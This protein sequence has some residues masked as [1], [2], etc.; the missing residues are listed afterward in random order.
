MSRSWDERPVWAGVAVRWPDGRITAVE[1][2]Y[3]IGE[4]TINTE[5]VDDWDESFRRGWRVRKPGLTS[6][7]VNLSGAL[8]RGWRQG[9]RAARQHTAAAI[10]AGPAAVESTRGGDTP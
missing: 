3:P 4:L 5:A 1:I 6:V 2:D 10:T 9:E 8:S 7:V